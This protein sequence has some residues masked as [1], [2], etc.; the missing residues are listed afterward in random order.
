MARHLLGDS[1][2]ILQRRREELLATDV[3]DFRALGDA[4]DQAAT[5]SRVVVLG[6][7]PAIAAANEKR[8]GFLAVS[9]VL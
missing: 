9:K 5:R 1:D 8:P 7:E 4:L 2:E 3:Q 6:S